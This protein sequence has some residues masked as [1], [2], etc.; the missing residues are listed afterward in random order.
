MATTQYT[1]KDGS[2]TYRVYFKHPYTNQQINL[3]FKDKALAIKNDELIKFWKKHE[4]E[5]FYMDE[6]HRKFLKIQDENIKDE[7]NITILNALEYYQTSISKKRAKSEFHRIEKLKFYL[8]DIDIEKL[9]RSD[10]VKYTD[11]RT[12]DHTVSKNNAT[13]FNK[14]VKIKTLQRELNILRTAISVFL[15]KTD[16]NHYK[17]LVENSGCP[18]FL[19]LTKH[20]RGRRQ[21]KSEK[22]KIEF[23][24]SNE[25]KRLY[26]NS[27]YHLQRAILI[28]D[29]LGVRFG[30]CELFNLKFSNIDFEKKKI[31]IERA[32]KDS[33]SVISSRTVAI[34]DF[35]CQ[36]IKAWKVEDQINYGENIKPT[37]YIINYKN[38]QVTTLKKSFNTA[39]EK[40]KIY[41]HFVPYNFRH[42]RITELLY[43]GMDCNSI[44]YFVGHTD[45]H[46]ILKF[47]SQITSERMDEIVKLQDHSPYQQ[48]T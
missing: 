23:L 11:M 5:K 28:A 42:M 18:V 25:K 34:S 36:K 44:A 40:A 46:M 1:N 33:G 20:S 9:Q 10:L 17:N 43:K 21:E 2:I 16:D 12:K 31:T 22:P 3:Q 48:T 47:Y 7:E 4:K 13:K 37:D 39:K 32:D 24:T 14:G 45:P 29:E 15:E 27:P 38:H 8:G 26:D 30:P 35:L 19:F 41:K 6:F